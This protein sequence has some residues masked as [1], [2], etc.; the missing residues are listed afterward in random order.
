MTFFVPIRNHIYQSSNLKTC[1][2][3]KQQDTLYE[4]KALVDLRLSRTRFH[5][6]LTSSVIKQYNNAT[7]APMKDSTA[8]IMCL[9]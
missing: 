8:R 1:L 3:F 4:P 5:S 2:S 6:F 9:N 7:I